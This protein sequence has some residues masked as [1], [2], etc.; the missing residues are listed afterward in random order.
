MNFITQNHG[1]LLE[2]RSFLMLFQ[3]FVKGSASKTFMHWRNCLNHMRLKQKLTKEAH[4]RL[5][6]NY[7]DRHLRDGVGLEKEVGKRSSSET[8][9]ELHNWTCI[10]LLKSFFIDTGLIARLCLPISDPVLEH[11]TSWPSEPGKCECHSPP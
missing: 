11:E 1:S 6:W 7:S 9:P 2:H 10:Y 3:D 5:F 4:P 8:T